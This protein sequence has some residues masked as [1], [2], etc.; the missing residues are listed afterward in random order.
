MGGYRWHEHGFITEVAAHRGCRAERHGTR[1]ELSGGSAGTA[2]SVTLTP[3]SGEDPAQI[4]W[5]CAGLRAAGDPNL[6]LVVRPAGGTG[7]TS[8][9]DIEGGTAGVVLAG[10]IVALTGLARR[11]ARERPA[12]EPGVLGP[13]WTVHDPAGVIDA[14]LTPWFENWPIAWWNP[15]DE[16]PARLTSV[17]LNQYGLEVRAEDWWCS[18]PALDQLIGLGVELAGRLRRAGF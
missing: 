13:N 18:A 1:W 3:A 5:R 10:V 8:L 12:P 7:G 16:R 11:R 9:G 2:W 4:L 15:G 14:G 17:W 6:Q